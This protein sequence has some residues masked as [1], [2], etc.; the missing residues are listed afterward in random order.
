MGISREM[1]FGGVVFEMVTGIIPHIYQE[2]EA[3]QGYWV[4]PCL[5]NR[6]GRIVHKVLG[7]WRQKVQ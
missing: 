6:D 7:S 5:Q 2:G 3:S 4:R 1:V